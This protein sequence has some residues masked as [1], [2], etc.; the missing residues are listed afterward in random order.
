MNTKYR[1]HYDNDGED[2]PGCSRE[3]TSREEAEDELERMTNPASDRTLLSTESAEA[4]LGPNPRV[5]AVRP[6]TMTDLGVSFDGETV[7]DHAE[8]CK[9]A[10]FDHVYVYTDWEGESFELKDEGSSE[11]IS[12]AIEA[13]IVVSGFVLVPIDKFAP[14]NPSQPAKEADAESR[15]NDACRGRFLVWDALNGDGDEDGEHRF[16][17]ADTPSEAAEAYAEQD[18]DGLTDGLYTTAH[19]IV[20]REPN[21]IE[22]RFNVSAETV[23][24]FHAVGSD[25]ESD[26]CTDLSTTHQ[27]QHRDQ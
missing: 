16:I 14:A 2:T 23:L 13:E 20:V 17:D 24:T 11:R 12:K 27:E 6:A 4:I 22:H 8:N 18:R 26:R 25:Q 7:L 3:F 1:I 10:A 15:P 5:C 21:G 9:E 19:P